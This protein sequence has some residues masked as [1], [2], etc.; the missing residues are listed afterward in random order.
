MARA[1][2]CRR[3][4]R[5]VLFSCFYLLMRAGP[6]ESINPSEEKRAPA[7]LGRFISGLCARYQRYKLR[8][9][10][11]TRVLSACIIRAPN[12]MRE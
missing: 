2:E 7:F 1:L 8:A 12:A 4:N 6:V 5:N 9:A 11:D 10:A 3:M